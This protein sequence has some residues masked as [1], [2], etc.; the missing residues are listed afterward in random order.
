MPTKM[1]EMTKAVGEQNAGFGKSLWEQ[2]FPNLLI[3]SETSA[4]THGYSV[5]NHASKYVMLLSNFGVEHRGLSPVS[6]AGFRHQLV[7]VPLTEGNVVK[8]VFDRTII[9]TSIPLALLYTIYPNSNR[10]FKTC[11]LT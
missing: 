2:E 8:H 11:K 9:C 4:N 6:E 7:L 10:I 3:Q 5:S 1:K